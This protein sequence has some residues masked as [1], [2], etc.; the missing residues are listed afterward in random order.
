MKLSSVLLA[1]FVSA[2]AAY[3]GDL[4]GH[5][6]WGDSVTDVQA[7]LATHCDQVR[8]VDVPQPSLPLAERTEHHVVCSGFRSGV[9]KVEAIAFA[10]ADDQLALAEAR[11]GAVAA[12][13][14]ADG[15]DAVSYL[16]YRV[17]GSERFSVPRDDTVWFVSEPALHPNLF[18]WASPHLSS[19]GALAHAYNPSAAIPGVLAFGGELD[20]LLAGFE[21]GC[22]FLAVEAIDNVWLPHGPASQTQVNCFGL[23]YAGFPRKVEAVFGDGMLEVAWILTG[24]PEEA[25][26]RDALVAEFGAPGLVSE[27]WE[28]FADGRVALRKDKPEVLMISE[29]MVP[30]YRTYYGQD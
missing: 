20:A 22:G 4:P 30:Y 19:V 15:E 21:E 25:R 7:R 3:A 29:R 18:T 2:S 23:E 12:F 27:T 6:A 24:K 26:V 9:G 14:A 5:V 16:H 11:G 17:S 28:V 10:F 1:V 8:L 13:G